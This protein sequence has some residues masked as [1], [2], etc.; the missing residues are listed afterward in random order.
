[1]FGQ[2]QFLN[3]FVKMRAELNKKA[4]E[5]EPPKSGRPMPE[6]RKGAVTMR[7]IIDDKPKQKVVADYFRNR[8][9]ELAAE[10]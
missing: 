7:E 6:V 10:D 2:N 1:M 9:K 4:V 8:V 5:S 3:N